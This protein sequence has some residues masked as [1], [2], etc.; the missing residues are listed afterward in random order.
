MKRSILVLLLLVVL[1][2][3]AGAVVHQYKTG[4]RYQEYYL[5]DYGIWG[6]ST[7]ITD[8]LQALMS[9]KTNSIFIAEPAGVYY[10]TY[11]ADS[12]VVPAG[13]VLDM[14]G[15]KWHFEIDGFSQA[16]AIGGHYAQIWGG[17]GTL[18]VDS[19]ASTL[20]P[21]GSYGDGVV[22]GD[23]STG[24]GFHDWVIRD[25]IIT[26]EALDGSGIF[27]T[28]DSYSGVIENVHIPAN[29]SMLC[30]VELHWGNPD[31][32]DTTG[33]GDGD[34]VTG[35]PHDIDI[36]N[37]TVDSLARANSRGIILAAVWNIRIKGGLVRRATTGVQIKNGDYGFA[38]MDTTMYSN[39]R[40]GIF[41]Q[42][43]TVDNFSA[44]KCVTGYSVT[45]DINHATYLKDALDTVNVRFPVTF[46]NCFTYGDSTGNGFSILMSDGVTI[47]KCGATEHNQGVFI[48]EYARGTVVSD[49]DFYENF[50]YGIDVH[51][52]SNPPDE[53]YIRDNRIWGNTTAGIYVDGALSVYIERNV[54]G[55]STETAQPFGVHIDDNQ[56]A[57]AYLRWN[58]AIASGAAFRVDAL[59]NFGEWQGNT[60]SG[61]GTLLRCPSATADANPDTID[62]AVMH[63]DDISGLGGGG[64]D[65][66]S[67]K[68]AAV[69]DT[70]GNLADDD[71]M[72]YDKASNTWL[73]EAPPGAAGGTTDSMYVKYSDSNS[74]ALTNRHISGWAV[75]LDTIFV[76]TT[77]TV[78]DDESTNDNHEIVFTTDNANLESDG[79]FHYNPAVAYLTLGTMLFDGS[80]SVL[81]S[82]SGD[83]TLGAVSGDVNINPSSG[84]NLG[85]GNGDETVAINSSDWG[86]D[87]TGIATGMGDITSDGTVTAE[88]IRADSVFG[89]V[90]PPAQAVGN[91]TTTKPGYIFQEP[92]LHIG[93][94][95]TGMLQI[96]DGRI[97][98]G[99]RDT[100]YNSD[101][102][103]L[104]GSFIFRCTSPVDKWIE[105]A[106]YENSGEL[107]FVIPSSG[108]SMGTV[109]LRSMFIA[110]PSVFND[111]IVRFD[112]WGFTKIDANTDA[113]GA[114]L[115]VQDDLEVMGIG[116]FD[117]LDNITAAPIE[118]LADLALNLNDVLG[119]DS[120]D[121]VKYTDGSLDP[122]DLADADFG[123]WTV[124]S[125]SATLDNDVVAP[126]EMADADHGDVSWTSGVASVEGG[127][128]DSSGAAIASDIIMD[129]LGAP[130][131]ST[132]QH[133]QN[134]FHSSGWTSGGAFT[135]TTDG[136]GDVDSLYVAAGTGLIRA[137]DLAADT[138][139]ILFFDWGDTTIAI[140][141][142]TT[143]FL[144]VEYNSG[145]PRVFQTTAD[146]SLLDHQQNFE[147]GVV[148]NEGG[149]L[150]VTF[151]PHSVGDHATTMI[152]RTQG[153]MGIQRDNDLGGLI[154]GETGTRNPTVTAGTLFS[155]LN[156]FA[157]SAIDLSSSGSMDR[158]Y[159]D[160]GTGFTK[161]AAVTTWNNTQWDDGDGGLATIN[162]NR[163][164]MQWFYLE[165]DGGLVSMFGRAEYV[166]LA[167]AEAESPPA[168]LPLRLTVNQAKLIGRLIFQES[169]ATA[170]EIQTVF[171]TVFPATAATDHGN[172]AG[173][174]DDD[175][176]QYLKESDTAA[177]ALTILDD[178]AVT[179]DLTATVSISAP[180]VNA[181]GAT[182][183]TV[184]LTGATSGSLSITV[185][186]IAGSPTEWVLP[187]VDGSGGN[188]LTTDGAGALSWAAAGGAGGSQ[189]TVYIHNDADNDSISSVD[190]RISLKWG[191]GID[192]TVAG[193][194]VTALVDETE[195]VLDSNQFATGA[196]S[197]SDD[198]RTFTETELE[199]QLSDVTAVF[200]N[201]VTGDVTVSGGT[202]TIG[203][204]TVDSNNIADG[205]LSIDDI[206]WDFEWIYL[207]LVHGF[208]RALSDSIYLSFPMQSA[209]GD[210]TYLLR[211]SA[212]N[213]TAGDQDT[214]TITGWVPFACVIDSVEVM[215]MITTGS[216][217][218]DGW[219]RGPDLSAPTGL[220]D[221]IYETFATDL[222][223]TTW[224]TAQ[225]AITDITA[226][227]GDRFGYKYIVQLDTD[228][229]ALRIGWIRL[230][231]R[232]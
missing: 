91:F 170:S 188:Q 181:T 63:Y 8:T 57:L 83:I 153:T 110:G 154:L 197:F 1:L 127:F 102:L 199:T 20:E 150:H 71:V 203:A 142:D 232:R 86:I 193:D 169:D 34:M 56:S 214:V 137:S 117:S 32:I 204:N 93:S 156:A 87:A 158:Y 152:E 40:E 62:V 213:I 166:S 208:G 224:D 58:K 168:T 178:P 215:Y 74:I 88:D 138:N 52:V 4:E 11:T 206:N 145:S 184:T 43:I 33:A 101:S 159:R 229:D 122:P 41:G 147:I 176:T 78:F 76:D 185:A 130:T 53:I 73:H 140:P 113:T 66:D 143:L 75:P 13:C 69:Q 21:G 134:I 126:A 97:I 202:S 207:Q 136:A 211:D 70:T 161:Q 129:T 60:E 116:F 216:E 195:L 2:A 80:S 82:N 16:L 10:F 65:A 223:A 96:G 132:V 104:G 31:A 139:T 12:I 186:D 47:D 39:T 103:D 55:D 25:L 167:G 23:Y 175:H 149:V 165:L 72:R 85:L 163:Y 45:G 124:S 27:A 114:D 22:V 99:T 148:T 112:Y 189:D 174:S 205:D 67:I 30:G 98:F 9:G 59:A 160:A 212:G 36:I 201:N 183:G 89:G 192:A 222:T 200:T 162:N 190:N 231:V 179:G 19:T 230:R 3:T 14:R 196:I 182:S 187:T 219:L 141:A 194:T 54:L 48:G 135:D 180:T 111:S 121:I 120:A 198:I 7:D 6:D 133:L 227:A 220:C 151:N 94:D 221:S 210:T 92:D 105:F 131:F 84:Q 108:D 81:Q 172:L 228:N 68:G 217:I 26:T 146:K 51:D 90:S 119:I 115:G 38:Y 164:A 24:V 173:L 109:N 50:A 118:V 18:D 64:A 46:T 61:S 107:R 155:K 49:G 5:K 209:N 191:N 218:V 144:G 128:S 44:W 226:V 157:I 15:S 100:L 106:F 37:L 125:G 29:T 177:F 171:T 17:G 225:Y 42:G 35:H 79:D 28:D 95:A 77:V 123:D